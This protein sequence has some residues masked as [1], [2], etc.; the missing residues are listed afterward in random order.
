MKYSESSDAVCSLRGTVQPHNVYILLHTSPEK[1][2]PTFPPR[3]PESKVHKRLQLAALKWGGVINWVWHASET[4]PCSNPSPSCCLEMETT[5]AAA[6]S[7]SMSTTPQSP[8]A[9]NQV[10]PP[11]EDGEN[12]SAT[13][14]SKNGRLEIH[15]VTLS[16]VEQVEETIRQFAIEDF[17]SSE[18]VA[19]SS[20]IGNEPDEVHIW[21]GT[22][23]VAIEAV[24]LLVQSMNRSFRGDFS[25]EMKRDMSVDTSSLSPFYTLPTSSSGDWYGVL[26]PEQVST[27]LDELSTAVKS[28][29]VRPLGKT[30]RVK[31]HWGGRM[32]MSK[33]EQASLAQSL[34]LGQKQQ[35]REV[36]DVEGKD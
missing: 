4:S 17:S 3:G 15:Q 12:Y 24:R 33:E 29:G 27:I 20:G 28:C 30:E 6:P 13:V 26:A 36:V 1:P 23:G 7:I 8:T 11:D 25:L 22:V 19:D 35:R 5:T 34:G 14:F 9:H 16:N 18:S 21:H 2:P 31:D 32:G 10:D